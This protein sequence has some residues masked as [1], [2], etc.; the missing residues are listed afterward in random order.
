MGNKHKRRLNRHHIHAKER[1]GGEF[2]NLVM[3]DSDYHAT[4]HVLDVQPDS[5]PAHAA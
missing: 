2:E 1:G 3:L 5:Q 4:W